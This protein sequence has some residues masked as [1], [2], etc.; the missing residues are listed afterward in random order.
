MLRRFPVLLLLILFLHLPS[1]VDGQA[2]WPQFRGPGGTGIAGGSA[3]LP[4]ELGPD[5]NCLWRSEIPFGLSSP[6]VW[7]DRIFLTG[8]EGTNLEALCIDRGTGKVLWRRSACYE[9][10]E[11]VHRT[12]SPATPTPVTDGKRVYIY[13]GSS[14]LL[15][16]DFAGNEVWSRIIRIPPNLYGT[17]S[18]L[19]LAGDLLIFCNDTDKGSHLEAINPANGETVWKTDR[20]DL[21]YNWTTPMVWSNNGITEIVVNGQEI[22]KAYAVKDGSERW[23]LPGLTDEP[24]VTPVPG[25]NGL[26]YVTSYN[27]KT[28]TEV[29]GLPPWKE[30]LATLDTDGDN[31]LTFAECKPNK[32]IL[33]RADADGEGDHP[34]WGFHRWLDAD[35]NGKVT[36]KEWQK[37]VQWV[38]S[39][40]QVN[41]LL[42]VRPGSGDSSPAEIVWKYEKGVPEC[43]SP[44][45]YDRL[46]Y[47]VKNGGMVTCLD[48]AGGELKY[49]ER[50]G[51]GGPYYAS[52]VAGDGKI[53]AASARGMVVVLAAG[54][55]LK[56][57][58]RNDLEDRIAATPAIAE[59]K[60]YLRTDKQLFAFGKGKEPEPEPATPTASS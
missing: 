32:S 42:A 26:I 44:L 1:L 24:I 20:T 12:N 15:C 33:S 29:I 4:V 27:M 45:Y 53:Y 58:A 48:A 18:S 46:V 16:Y 41:A 34:L 23:L 25:P 57:L 9:F 3:S 55:Q 60:I 31:Q 28:N 35:K 6:V 38:D 40:P 49:Q 39:F 17:A 51:A 59:G 50:L 52:P 2:R 36:E 37:I 10:I 54:A 47:L 11:R 19:I 43:P 56:V 13:L 30:L 21:K 7:G 14:G 22:M 8:V 5:R